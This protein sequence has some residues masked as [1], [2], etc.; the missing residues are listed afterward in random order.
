MISTR[1]KKFINY[2]NCEIEVTFYLGS[3]EALTYDKTFVMN[4]VKLIRRKYGY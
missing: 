2:W 3:S 1:W 4:R